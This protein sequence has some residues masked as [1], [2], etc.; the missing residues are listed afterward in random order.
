ML[1]IK[2]L[3][4][5]LLATNILKRAIIEY[6]IKK[7]TPFHSFDDAIKQHYSIFKVKYSQITID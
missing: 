1:L 6:F 4:I 3:M 7:K 5:L 2:K